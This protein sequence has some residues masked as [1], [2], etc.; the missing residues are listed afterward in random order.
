MLNQNSVR[1]QTSLED[2]KIIPDVINEVKKDDAVDMTVKFGSTDLIDGTTLSKEEVRC[3][4]CYA[5]LM[6]AIFNACSESLPEDELKL[7]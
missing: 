4:S 5:L 6:R 1:M 2:S 3:C 7:L